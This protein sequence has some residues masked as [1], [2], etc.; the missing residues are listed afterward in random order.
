MKQKAIQLNAQKAYLKA[1]G[2]VDERQLNME[3]VNITDGVYAFMDMVGSALIRKKFQPRDYFLIL[4]LCHQIAADNASRYACRVDNFIGDSV[5]LVNA[6]PFDEQG[7]RLSPA[8]H[9]R[10]MLMV[11][12]L[13]SI[14]NEIRLLASGRHPM[15]KE[16]RIKEIIDKAKVSLGFRAGLE[17]GPAM[18]GPLGSRKRRIVTAIGKAVNTASRL[19]STGITNEIHISDGALNLVR[20]ACVTRD[21]VTIWKIL[22]TSDRKSVV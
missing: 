15:D 2:A 10:A 14:F 8:A 4:N 17:I 1:V 9:E 16:G 21:T 11:F 6:S 5:F 20:E 22:S 19:E 7:P 13:A 12:A 3:A 18:I